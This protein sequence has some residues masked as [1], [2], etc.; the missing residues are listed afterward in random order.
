[1]KFNWRKLTIEDYPMLCIWWE[2]WGWP[3]PPTLDMLPEGYLAYDK[4]DGTPLYAGFLYKTGTSLGWVEYVVSNKDCPVAQKR[5]ALPYLLDIISVIAKSA[6][7][8]HLFS[9]T[10]NPSYKQSLIGCEFMIGDT[11]MTQLIREL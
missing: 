2:Q 8:T 10:N 11:N 1:M 5:G 4:E 9:S 7:I 3:T 6:G